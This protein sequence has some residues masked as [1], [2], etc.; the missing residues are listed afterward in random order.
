MPKQNETLKM[1]KKKLKIENKIMN[2]RARHTFNLTEYCCTF[3]ELWPFST[4]GFSTPS[5]RA[6]SVQ[7]L[8]SLDSNFFSRSKRTRVLKVLPS[9]LGGIEKFRR[10]SPVSTSAGMVGLQYRI[11]VR[12]AFSK[13]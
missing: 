9:L 13:A 3:C 11:N 5:S 2:G 8:I 4:A 1:H 12:Y 10:S 7:V 6:S